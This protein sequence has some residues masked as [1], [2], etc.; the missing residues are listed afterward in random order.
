[1]K[2]DSLE[3]SQL[4]KPIFLMLFFYIFIIYNA[5]TTNNIN[6]SAIYLN[7]FWPKTNIIFDKLY[8]NIIFLEYYY[9]L[10]YELIS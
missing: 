1:M 5:I 6:I 10:T 8:H 7:Q 4:A 2:K 9:L 3:Q